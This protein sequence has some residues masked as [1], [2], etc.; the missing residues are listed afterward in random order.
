MTRYILGNLL[1]GRRIVDLNVI[2][3]PWQNRLGAPENISVTL[4]LNDPDNQALGLR[5]SATPAQSFLAVVENDVVMAAGP[6]WSRKY[7]RADGTL[8]LDA[9]GMASLFNHR[10]IL[11]LLARTIGVDQ[12]TIPDPLDSTKTI[13]NPALAT[14]LTNVSLA[15]RAKRLIQQAQSWTGGNVPVVFQADEADVS[16]KTYDGTD[17]KSIGEAITDITKLQN[18]PEIDLRGRFTADSLGIEWVLRAGTIA[19]PM[20]TSTSVLSWN[21]T[22]PESAVKDLI[23][24]EDASD[25]ASLAWQTGGRSVADILVARAYDPYLLNANFPLL[26][27][28]DSSHT[29]V[30]LQVTLDGYALQDATLGRSAANIWSMSVRANPDGSPPVG[31]YTVGDFADLYIAPFDQVLG[32]GDLFYPEGGTY[33]RRIVGISGD[34][35]GE[36]IKLDFAQNVGG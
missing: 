33:R 14:V 35:V 36:W 30:S 4:D 5:N 31:S 23:I 16:T 15:T 25:M 11:P 34:A 10:L 17:F 26:E 8:E 13:A 28:L 12:W 32:I 29:D 2:T 7:S 27:K 9:L 1:T 20:I 6:I 24:N 18:G 22:A 19:Q 3:G 21:I